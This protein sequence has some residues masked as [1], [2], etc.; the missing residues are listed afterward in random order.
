[1]MTFKS[2]IITLLM[3]V[4]IPVSTLLILVKMVD[5]DVLCNIVRSRQK[6]GINL[7][8]IEILWRT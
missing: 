2:A 5:V 7:G 1:M 4:I 3:A 6:S 8:G